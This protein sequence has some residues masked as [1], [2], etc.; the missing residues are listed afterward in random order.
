MGIS[1]LLA[2]RQQSQRVNV[3]RLAICSLFAILFAWQ[4]APRQ[5]SKA[6][7]EKSDPAEALR[8]APHSGQAQAAM[9]ASDLNAGRLSSAIHFATSA[10]RASPLSLI[11]LRS[12]IF[13]SQLSGNK[14]KAAQLTRSAEPTGWRDEPMQIAIFANDLQSGQMS[15]AADRLDA[16]AR[17]TED[18]SLIYPLIDS[19]LRNPDFRREIFR[20]LSLDP[21]WRRN[22]LTRISDLDPAAVAARQQIAVALPRH[23]QDQRR[24]ELAPYASWLFNQGYFADAY[25]FWRDHLAERSLLGQGPI[26]DSN[27]RSVG[28]TQ[29]RT[30][31]DWTL[32]AL[33]GASATPEQDG[34]TPGL[35]VDTDGT[36]DGDL[37]EQKLLLHPGT[38]RFAIDMNP[39]SP[40]PQDAFQWRILCGPQRS[41]LPREGPATSANAQHGGGVVAFS[42]TVPDN[43]CPYQALVLTLSRTT[44]PEDTSVSFHDPKIQ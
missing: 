2:D 25:R 19:W 27:F 41:A 1:Q 29:A 26:F 32:R 12:L 35:S 13:A 42:F 16:V 6:A 4:I 5:I 3:F 34:G 7:V 36:V 38:Y 39:A 20:R 43:K 18:P 10:L 17:T 37:I 24:T 14:V 30:P 22:Y 40:P 21:S 9:A 31:F 23:S 8:I 28:S 44:I 11:A 33:T 15:D